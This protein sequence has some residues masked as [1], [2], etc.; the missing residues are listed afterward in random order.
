LIF[1]VEDGGAIRDVAVYALNAAG[2]QA[3]G[4]GDGV[5]LFSALPEERPQLILLDIMLPGGDGISILKR[6]RANAA[7]ASI[8]VIMATAKGT[9]YDKATGLD[10]G[11]DG[12]LAKPFGM[13]GP[14]S[15]VRAVLRGARPQGPRILRVGS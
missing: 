8:P 5:E 1:C 12:Y 9:E 2:F 14:A 3:G 13:M 15:Q 4:L 11:A 10:L 6:L 7:T